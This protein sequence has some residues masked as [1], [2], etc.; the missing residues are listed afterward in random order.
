M[1]AVKDEVFTDPQVINLLMQIAGP[2]RTFHRDGYNASFNDRLWRYYLA[3][4]KDGPTEGG[5]EAIQK[6]SSCVTSDVGG[7][8]RATCTSQRQ[9]N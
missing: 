6:K 5:S 7:K 9:K 2:M 1:A 3:Q 8:K 4:Q